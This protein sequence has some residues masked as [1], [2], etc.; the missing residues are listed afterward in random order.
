MVRQKRRI[1]RII[2]RPGKKII[3]RIIRIRKPK[4]R[5]IRKK[6]RTIKIVKKTGR[7]PI[8][9]IRRVIRR[10]GRRI[11]VVK[12][13][14]KIV[15]II[16][17]KGK[18]TVRIV[19]RI[20]KRPGKIIR[21]IRKP[22]KIIRIIRRKG[23][24]PMKIIRRPGKKI[25]KIIRRPGRVIRI[26]R[27]P[28][29]KP[30]RIIKRPGKKIIR[31]RY[32]P[33]ISCIHRKTAKQSST[34]KDKRVKPFNPFKTNA[35][36]ARWGKGR[37]TCTHTLNDKAGA[38]WSV[39]FYGTP[40]V[41]RIQI[42][43]RADCC[44]NRL[45]GAKVFIGKTLYGTIKNPKQGAWITL[46]GKKV[47]GNMIKIVGAPKQYLHFCG[48]KVFGKNC[49]RPKPRIIK[50]G[51]KVIKIIRKPGRRIIRII[52]RPGKKV[53]RIIRRGNRRPV[54]II[55]KPGKRTVKIIRR[56][57][58]IIRIITRPGKKSIR[59]VKRPG[60]KPKRR[61][62]KPRPVGRPIRCMNRESAKQSSTWKDKRVKPFN[63]FKTN[64]FAPRWGSG[65]FTCTH[66]LNDARGAWW[67]VNFYGNPMIY[68]ISILNRADCCGKRINNAKVFVGS[69]LCGVIKNPRQGSWLTV[70]C[71]AKGNF[72]KIVGAPKQ[73]L[74]FCGIRAWGKGC[75][76]RP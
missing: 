37:F 64:R 50:K 35:F 16:R 8:R 68:R 47:R 46:S 12:K 26:I 45:N 36:N 32:Y 59:I 60:K 23:R 71:R 63:P 38:W 58:K 52:R 15:R 48:I 65:A 57:R 61:V 7:K 53:I 20:I 30:V 28:G 76:R 40:M 17:R 66:T 70:N 21:I 33:R 19:R 67:Q 29:R 73:Y 10:P 39:E 18:R 49:G 2:K 55:G 3:R 41:T 5:V 56:R 4:V 51:K 69:K 24:L 31:K 34:W 14:R 74:H 25:V 13:P 62:F 11:I 43:N 22:R 27:K 44:G 9:I 75:G 1:I 6:G 72:I 42:L 54:R